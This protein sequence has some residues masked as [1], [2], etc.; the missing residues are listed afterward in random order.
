MAPLPATLQEAIEHGELTEDQL[1]ELIR[2]EAAELGLT[3][4]EAVQRA[5]EGTLPH[6]L[7]G[8]DIGMLVELLPA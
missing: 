7:L 4:D 8:T 5:R 3:F 6:D 2:L 1:R